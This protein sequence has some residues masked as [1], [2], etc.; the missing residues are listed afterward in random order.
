M[1]E[2][3][4]YTWDR[5]KQTPDSEI[6]KILPQTTQA[7]SSI[8]ESKTLLRYLSIP[9]NNLGDIQADITIMVSTRKNLQ[10]VLEDRQ[11][12]IQRISDFITQSFTKI[13]LV[14]SPIRPKGQI[15][16]IDNKAK[17]LVHPE[18]PEQVAMLIQQAI[19]EL[20]PIR[21]DHPMDSVYDPKIA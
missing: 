11:T 18:H 8:N 16:I 14:L 2:A 3:F 1:I 20:Q 6:C 7:I 12:E 9:D 5:N 17:V 13:R 4:S 21:T 10:R 15:L 19:R